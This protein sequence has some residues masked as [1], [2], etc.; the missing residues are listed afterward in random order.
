VPLKILSIGLSGHNPGILFHTFAGQQYTVQYSTGLVP[1]IWSE[2][3]GRPI[4]GTGFEA[5]VVDTN[6]TA[7]AN[8]R[9]YRLKQQ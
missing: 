7:T 1:G 4:A 5:V 9:F 3:P 2:L 6:A 8:S